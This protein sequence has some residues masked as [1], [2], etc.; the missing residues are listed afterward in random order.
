MTSVTKRIVAIKQPRGGYL[1]KEQ[2]ECID[3]ED[4]QRL[5]DAENLAANI[6]GLAVDYLTRWGT[7]VRLVDAFKVSLRGACRYDAVVNVNTSHKDSAKENAKKLIMEMQGFDNKAILNACKLVGYDVCYRA[8]VNGFKPVELL[9]PDEN[10]IKNIRIMVER[11]MRFWNIYGPVTKSGFTFEGGY[12]EIISSGDGSYLSRDTLWDFTVS[13][14]ELNSRNTLQLLVY[15]IMA[16]HSIHKEFQ[17]IK[18]LGLFNPRKNK[19]YIINVAS[20]EPKVM[21]EVAKT[22]I[23]YKY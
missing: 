15:Y 5:N 8:G 2:F 21:D 18:K 7:G 20:I 14:D 6:V 22:I 19:V 13:K 10:T 17:L 16:Q 12:T 9:V 3:L 1:P 11:S 4:G 23:G